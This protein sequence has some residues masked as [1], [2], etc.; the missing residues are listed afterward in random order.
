MLTLNT[1]RESF[2]PPDP[3]TGGDITI[4]QQSAK[5][6]VLVNNGETVVIAGLTSNEKTNNETGIPYLK[7]IPILGYLFKNSNKKTQKS[8][9]IIFVTPYIIHSEIASGK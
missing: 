2:V 7:S 1:S 5:T 6:N 8:D 9:L 4:R 3:G